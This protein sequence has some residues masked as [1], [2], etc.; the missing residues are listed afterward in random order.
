MFHA[1]ITPY[2]LA[3]G[4]LATVYFALTRP[5]AET[6]IFGIAFNF[7]ILWLVVSIGGRSFKGLSHLRRVPG[8]VSLAIVM[9]FLMLFVMLPVKIVFLATMNRQGC[10][11]SRSALTQLK[12]PSWDHAV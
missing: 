8:D 4:A 2:T 12:E 3:I 10:V 1:T 7:P 9:T 6:T 5:G 11:R